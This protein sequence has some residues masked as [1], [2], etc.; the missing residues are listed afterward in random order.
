MVATLFWCSLSPRFAGTTNLSVIRSCDCLR[1]LKLSFCFLSLCTY[2][3]RPEHTSDLDIAFYW[4]RTSHHFW[5]YAGTISSTVWQL[6]PISQ[7]H[8]AVTCCWEPQACGLESRCRSFARAASQHRWAMDQALGR[9]VMEE[10][11]FVWVRP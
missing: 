2:R 11:G 3:S 8:C 4:K 7:N 5:H 6:I 10:Y 9:K 1:D